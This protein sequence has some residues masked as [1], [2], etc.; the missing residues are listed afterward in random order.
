MTMN[1]IE[2]N[3]TYLVGISAGEAHVCLKP[4]HHQAPSPAYLMGF[5]MFNQSVSRRSIRI[6]AN[7]DLLRMR[8]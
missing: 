1:L 6:A 8:K 2:A 3:R 4:I 5:G 7:I